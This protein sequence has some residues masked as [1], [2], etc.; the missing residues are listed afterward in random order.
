MG[1]LM[2][3]NWL[4]PRFDYKPAADEN[5]FEITLTVAAFATPYKIYTT[6]KAYALDRDLWNQLRLSV[7]DATI[8]VT[9]RALTLSSTG[10]VQVQPSAPATSSFIIAPV[11]APGKIV[12]WALP[13]DA[14]SQEQ[15]GQL[16]GFGIGEESVETVLTGTQVV[17]PAARNATPPAGGN[18]AVDS[19]I[20]CHAATPDGLGVGFVFGPPQSMI[21]SDTYFDTVVSIAA[22]A[23]GQVPSIVTPAA[24]ATVRSLRGIP[25]FSLSHW[26]AGD[27]IVLLTDA[28]NQG[29]LRW[30]E[31]GGGGD[32]LI[33]RTGDSNG[34]VEPT[35]SHDGRSIVYVSTPPSSIHDGRLDTNPADLYVVPYADRA[36]GTAKPLPGASD[37]AVMEYYPAFSPDD[38]WV[39]YTGVA[40]P[41][42]S[43][44]VTSY[45]NG[46][47][48]L[49]VIAANGGQPMRLAANDSPACVGARS[50]GQTNDWPKWSPEATP[51]SNGRTYYWLTFSSKRTGRA[52]LYVTALVTNGELGTL[53]TYP[54]LYLWNQPSDQ[55]NH[56]PSW[57]NYIIPPVP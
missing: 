17:A 49:F 42:G 31:L 12:Y 26:S 9:V 4:R 45:S 13:Q 29:Q 32:G 36:G 46:A 55:G 20:G 18:G 3:R 57:D 5:L 27:S 28:N 30:V 41:A 14:N 38:S 51:A 6:S 43:Q 53:E 56:T 40:T 33:A 50:P 35:F 47:A 54:A 8:T 15:D 23:E 11:D 19:C 52:Q 48:E 44:G 39:A 2:P 21:G 1:T 7:N 24:L 25:A 34:A 22:G 37:P 10:T 16:N